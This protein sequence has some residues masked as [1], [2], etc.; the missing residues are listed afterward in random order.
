MGTGDSRKSK[1]T[2][3]WKGQQLKR[4]PVS[5]QALLLIFANREWLRLL[6]SDT[7]EKHIST[8][9]A[10]KSILQSKQGAAHTVTVNHRTVWKHGYMKKQTQ[11]T[12]VSGTE[13]LSPSDDAWASAQQR[14]SAHCSV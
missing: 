13:F 1:A 10:I 5:L 2:W 8:H 9:P 6:C 14:G 12:L 4:F 7:E 11:E 3:V